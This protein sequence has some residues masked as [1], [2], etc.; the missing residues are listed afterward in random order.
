MTTEKNSPNNALFH[1][2]L[3]GDDVWAIDGPVNDLM[4]LVIGKDKALLVDTGMGF[5]DLAGEVRRLTKLPVIVVNTHGHP[6]HAGGNA[7]FEK[8]F[9]PNPDQAIREKMC[10]SEYRMN[11]LRA[12]H[13][14]TST[15]FKEIAPL[16]LPDKTVELIPFKIGYIF[17]LGGRQ[18]EVIGL[19]GHTPGCIALLNSAERMLFSGDSI[20]QTPVWLYLEHSLPFASYL[21]SL[22]NLSH[23]QTEF[24]VIYPGHNPTALQKSAFYDLLE[25]A[26]QIYTHSGNRRMDTYICG[27]RF[28][29]EICGRFNNI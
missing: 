15:Q 20:V 17:D 23:R 9:F 26:S 29:V 19:P 27:G 11:D 5:G 13:S 1:S 6:D 4:H 25:C 21:E 8:V 24:E 3:V 2:H 22:E 12:F 14:E 28:A 18:L 16:L 10:T 7:N